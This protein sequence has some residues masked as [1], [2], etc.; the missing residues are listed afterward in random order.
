[1]IGLCSDSIDNSAS[2]VIVEQLVTIEEEEKQLGRKE[3][4]EMTNDFEGA[5]NLCNMRERMVE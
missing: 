5:V 2:A 4:V 3:W 1:M